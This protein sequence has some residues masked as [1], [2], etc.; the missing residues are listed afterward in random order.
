MPK[1]YSTQ[2]VLNAITTCVQEMHAEDI[3]DADFDKNSD[4]IHR[5]IEKLIFKCLGKVTEARKKLR[6]Q[7]LEEYLDIYLELS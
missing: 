7:G 6:V 3:T 2:D 5:L 1:Y 4:H